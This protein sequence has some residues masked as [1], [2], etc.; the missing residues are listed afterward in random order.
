MVR[1]HIAPE[2]L[3]N[4]A[5]QFISAGGESRQQANTLESALKAFQWEGATK[6]RF[7]NDFE[8]AKKAMQS[9]CEMLEGIAQQLKAIA[10]RF[11]AADQG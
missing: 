3:R 1:I 7:Y 10:D 9:Y 6:E 2:D 4:V 8:Q 5:Q 11:E